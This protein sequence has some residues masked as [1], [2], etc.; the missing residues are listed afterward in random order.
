MW[1]DSG[2]QRFSELSEVKGVSQRIVKE[3]ESQWTRVKSM[4]DLV[5]YLQVAWS[6]VTH[7]HVAL[8]MFPCVMQTHE[9]PI[10]LATRLSA[11]Y[12]PSGALAVL[13][14]NPYALVTDVRCVHRVMYL[15]HR[16]LMSLSYALLVSSRL[17][18]HWVPYC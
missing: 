15:C 14:T 17:Q 16:W 4:R 6:W 3:M 2:A 9:L 13:K 5:V 7:P 11:V 1:P 10:A 8:V 12:S 18:R